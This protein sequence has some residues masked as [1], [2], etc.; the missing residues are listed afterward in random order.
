[1][2][3]TAT[4]LIPS[5]LAENAQTTQYTSTDAK[6]II[7]TFTGTNNTAGNVTLSINLVALGGAAGAANLVVPTRTIAPGECYRFDEIIGQVLE[8]GGFISTIASAA[9]SI[10]IRASGRVITT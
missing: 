2:T 5:K 7:D 6:T 8:N 3:V 4:N 9:A 10:V 1:M